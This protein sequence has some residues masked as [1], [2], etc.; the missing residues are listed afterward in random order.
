MS[1]F[2]ERLEQIYKGVP[3]PLG[4]GAP[5]APR[6]PGLALVALISGAHSKGVG[7][8]AD[9]KPDAALFAG[10]DGQPALKELAQSLG[11]DLPW[12]ARVHSLTEESAQAYQ[13]AGC[14]YLAFSLRG[15]AVAAVGSEELAGILCVD[16]DIESDQLRAISG[17][18]VDALLLSLPELSAPLTLE[19]LT[20]IT[21]I[22]RLVDKFIMVE[23]SQLPGP[24]EL[25]PLRSTGV[26][27]LVVDVGN[28]DAE[29][30]AKLKAALLDMPRQRPSRRERVTAIIP[31]SAFPSG[32]IPEREEPE[33]DEDE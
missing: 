27:G 14:D 13:D 31:S 19:D 32:S 33:P 20:A 16:G 7:L 12:G 10:V 8:V 1:K 2:L 29:D 22:S 3:A 4:F 15:T 18:P 24:K 23:M 9:L 30:L 26:H 28:V 21:R 25:E 11:S 6:T 5:R 17:L